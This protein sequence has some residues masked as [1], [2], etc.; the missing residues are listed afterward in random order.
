MT[1]IHI[2]AAHDDFE[3]NGGRGRYLLLPGSRSRAAK[4][5]EQFSDVS[6]K[7][8]SRGHDLYTGTISRDGMTL[9]VGVIAT[10]MGCPSIDLI[11]TELIGLGAKVL[12]RVGTS[13]SLQKHVK[14]GDV[15]VATAAVRDEGAS[16]NYL[17][18]EI[19]ALAAWPLVV[20]S[21]AASQQAK[22]N[23]RVHFGAVH[24]KDTLYGREF[25]WGPLH[26]EHARYNKLLTLSGVLAS[27]MEC[28]HLFVLG[29]LGKQAAGEVPVLA[30]GVLAVIGDHDEPFKDS[31]LAALAVDDAIELA[32]G[33]F[34]ELNQAEPAR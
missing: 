29:Q 1:P 7:Q 15:V 8:H 20:A 26:E 34:A 25:K 4:I 18:R 19:P 14:T 32:F 16:D 33:T 3:G 30:G 28:A 11:V 22:L 12:L 6:I 10:G 24:T 23:G 17:P 5:A 27:E 9:D 13:G 2:N 21:L 31:P